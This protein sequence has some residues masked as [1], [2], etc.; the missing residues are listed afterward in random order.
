M[1]MAST[2][3]PPHTVVVRPPATTT[4]DSTRRA[5]SRPTTSSQSRLP[6]SAEIAGGGRSVSSGAGS[7]DRAPGVATARTACAGVV[8]TT[9]SAAQRTP[10]APAPGTYSTYS[11]TAATRS[12]TNDACRRMSASRESCCSAVPWLGGAAR[13][14]SRGS[15]RSRTYDPRPRMRTATAARTSR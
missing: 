10:A 12:A 11:A 8:V 13:A 14:G 15:R 1:T 7:A 3:R 4:D 5:E 9:V 2:G 6:E